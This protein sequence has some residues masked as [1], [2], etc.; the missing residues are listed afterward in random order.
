MLCS[1]MEINSKIR[2]EET[3]IQPSLLSKFLL[4]IVSQDAL[5]TSP[6]HSAQSILQSLTIFINLNPL[7]K[8]DF[9]I[10][11]RRQVSKERIGRLKNIDTP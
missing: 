11:A 5:L 3:D 2:P 9:K 10:E 7:L 6:V 4:G 8:S 1:A